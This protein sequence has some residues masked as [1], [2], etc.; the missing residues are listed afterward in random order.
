MV[1]QNTFKLT[2]MNLFKRL[3]V[4]LTVNGKRQIEVKNLSEKNKQIK[5]V[6]KNYYG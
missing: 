5:T 3:R 4:T 1:Q 6:Q 2:K